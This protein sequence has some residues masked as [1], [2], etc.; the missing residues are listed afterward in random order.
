MCVDPHR[1]KEQSHAIVCSHFLFLYLSC[2]ISSLGT[3][4]ATDFAEVPSILMEYFATDYRVLSQFA[5]HYE[6]GQVDPNL[7]DKEQ[8]EETLERY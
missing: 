7:E 6:T 2:N 3:R 5:R 8:Y 4:C 1:K